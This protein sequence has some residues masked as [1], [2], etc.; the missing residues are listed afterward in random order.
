MDKQKHLDLSSRITIEKE[1]NN[2]SSFKKIAALV[3]KDCSTISKE[4]R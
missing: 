4:V 2:L 3:G 1:L